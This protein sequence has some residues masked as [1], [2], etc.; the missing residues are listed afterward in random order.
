VKS[1]IAYFM[2]AVVALASVY[3][4]CKKDAPA[5][6]LEGSGYPDDIGQI[7]LGNCALSGCHNDASSHVTAGLNLSSWEKCMQGDRNG[8]VVIPYSHEFSTMF[9]YCNTYADLGLMAEPTMPF[10]DEPLTRTQIITLRNWINSG[11]PSRTGEIPFS[12]NSS[13]KKIY[14][15]NQGCDVVTVIDAGS[16]FPMRYIPV[17][18]AFAI[19]S[20]HGLRLSPDGEYW[21][22]CF[23]NG[24]YLEKYR[25]SDDAFVGRILLGSNVAAA[26]G[27]WNTFAI[28]PDGQHAFVVHWDPNG[29]GRIA[30]VDLD[31]MQLNQVYQSSLLNQTHGSAVSPDGNTLYVTTTTGNFIYKFDVSDPTSPSFDQIVI[32]GVSPVPIPSSSEN[33]HEI[34]IAP[35]GTKY[36]ITCSGTNNVRVFDISTDTLITTIPV[37]KYPQE[38]VISQ[39]S[40]YGYITC[41]EDTTT[42]PGK[43]GSVYAFDWQTNSLVGSVYT[44]HQPHGITID[45][46][47]QQVIV[48]NRNI[49]PGGPAP[50][51]TGSCG[52][53]NGNVAFIDMFA[54]TVIEDKDLEVSADP[55]ACLYRP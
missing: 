21:Y 46:D 31:A 7:I 25:T 41:T 32:D 54:L 11:A 1:R 43:R 38:I 16:G 12:G 49:S 40:A 34:A 6:D 39:T 35:D 22:V 10:N 53:R 48:A 20:P 4:S 3:S 55:Y 18:S 52:G 42:Y 51:H 14:V 13:R 15:T 19:E 26:F 24:S 44:G 30:W 29:A 5:I 23:A 50:H 45:E 9:M 47:L 27:S 36:F 2:I 37:G 28:T 33:G 8:A 17:G